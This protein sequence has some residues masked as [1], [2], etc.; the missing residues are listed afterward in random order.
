MYTRAR[1]IAGRVGP[2]IGPELPL[3]PLCSQGVT[4]PVH[5]ATLPH[6]PSLIAIYSTKMSNVRFYTRAYGISHH[7]RRREKDQNVTHLAREFD[8]PVSAVARTPS[9]VAMPSV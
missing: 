1:L 4:V 7:F 9:T 5:S 3:A 6:F 2:M 8:V